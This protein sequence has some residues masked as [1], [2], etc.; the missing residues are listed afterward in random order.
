MTSSFHIP[1]ENITTTLD[2]VPCLLHLSIEGHLLD[3][4][5]KLTKH[6]GIELVVVLRGVDLEDANWEVHITNDAYTWFNFLTLKFTRRVQTSQ[7]G[8]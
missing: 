3:H 7:K 4:N 1:V 6:E 2:D 8:E 5:E